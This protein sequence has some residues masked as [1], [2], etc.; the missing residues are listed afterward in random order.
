MF[1]RRFYFTFYTS[2][3]IL[4]S[5]SDENNVELG[6]RAVRIFKEFREYVNSTSKVRLAFLKLVFSCRFRLTFEVLYIT[7]LQ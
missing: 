1:I 2:L 5:L 3:T 4:N 6:D 7:N